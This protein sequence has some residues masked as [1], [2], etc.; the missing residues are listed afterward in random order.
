MQ[1]VTKATRCRDR[2]IRQ[3]GHHGRRSSE[4]TRCRDHTI[5]QRGHRGPAEGCRRTNLPKLLLT[6]HS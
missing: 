4:A 1:A 5:R 3:R 2:A 6:R